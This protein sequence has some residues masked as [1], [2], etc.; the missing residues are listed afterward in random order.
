VRS[1]SKCVMVEREDPSEETEAAPV[2][3]KASPNVLSINDIINAEDCEMIEADVPE[4]GGIVFLKVLT[5]KERESLFAKVNAAKNEGKY[6]SPDLV[7]MCLCDQTG[8]GLC[9]TEGTIKAI[10]GKSSIVIERLAQIAVE[11]N[12]LGDDAVENAAKN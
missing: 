2:E 5:G 7:A 3:N 8:E 10:R 6:F 9:R 4:W 11:L 12:G 1:A